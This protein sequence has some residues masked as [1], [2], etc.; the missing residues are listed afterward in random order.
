M[1]EVIK[2]A[3]D[4]SKPPVFPIQEREKRNIEK[5][6]IP[7]GIAIAAFVLGQILPALM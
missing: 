6:A 4:A 7:V 2:A 1:S 3:N 5:L